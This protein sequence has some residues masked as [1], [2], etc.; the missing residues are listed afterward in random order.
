MSDERPITVG[1]AARCA[2]L[3]PKAIR[4]YEAH[5]LLD[6]AQR[7]DAGYRTFSEHDLGVLRF[8]RQAK[9]IGL[10]LKDIKDVIDLQRQGA[11]PCDRV[12]QLLD[13]RIREIDQTMAD[14]KALRRTLSRAQAEAKA[15]SQQ[16]ASA[17]V[18]RIIESATAVTQESDGPECEPPV[19]GSGSP[20]S[21]G[22]SPAN[23]AAA[24]RLA[25][26]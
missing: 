19:A 23:A 12:L 6:L 2:G 21:A 9:A 25:V 18:C 20:G 24:P 5:G 17:T 10:P 8:I 22:R 3:T 14:L 11:Q 1:A 16:G 13:T 26:R 4:L 7:T 15:S